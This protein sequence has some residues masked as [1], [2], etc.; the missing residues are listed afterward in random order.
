MPF[1]KQCKKFL[2][3]LLWKKCLCCLF[4]NLFTSIRKAVAEKKRLIFHPLFHFQNASPKQESKAPF[5]S[6]TLGAV[7]KHLS[8][9]LLLLEAYLQEDGSEAA[10]GLKYRQYKMGCGS[11]KSQFNPFCHNTHSCPLYIL[12]KKNSVMMIIILTLFRYIH[13]CI[14]FKICLFRAWRSGLLA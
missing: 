11:P 2:I 10:S 12:T 3:L 8:H 5:W 14:Y 13:M 4:L 9:H 6:P 1:I 7:T